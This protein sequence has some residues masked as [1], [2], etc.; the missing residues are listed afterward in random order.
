MR[1]ASAVRFL[2]PDPY[3]ASERNYGFSVDSSERTSVIKSEMLKLFFRFRHD[4]ISEII[5]SEHRKD[6]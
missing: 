4:L 2:A 5:P 3:P 1:E 6:S